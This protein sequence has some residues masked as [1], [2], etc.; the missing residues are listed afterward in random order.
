MWGCSSQTNRRP[1]SPGTCPLL[2]HIRSSRFQ[3]QACPVHDAV[4][5]LHFSLFP[6]F[7]PCPFGASHLVLNC[8]SVGAA[9]LVTML[10]GN[11]HGRATWPRNPSPWPRARCHS[12]HMQ[13]SLSCVSLACP[14]PCT[15][16]H[17]VLLHPACP[18]LCLSSC[19]LSSACLLFAPAGVVTLLHEHKL[20]TAGEQLTPEQARLLVRILFMWV[21]IFSYGRFCHA[22][23]GRGRGGEGRK[24]DRF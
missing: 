24:G 4:F 20:C 11:M 23:G 5:H 13:S 9:G 10:C 12:S 8:W 21:L 3:M 17:L 16:V 22:K 1:K 6:L 15:E 14:R 7:L 2:H 18:P 19:A